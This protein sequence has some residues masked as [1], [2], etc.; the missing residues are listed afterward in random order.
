MMNRRCSTHSHEL[1]RGRSI[2]VMNIL[3]AVNSTQVILFITRPGLW[4]GV[5]VTHLKLDLRTLPSG[6]MPGRVHVGDALWACPDTTRVEI[7]TPKKKARPE[8]TGLE[9]LRWFAPP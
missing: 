8:A 9:N 6:P 7:R 1:E 2:Q 5:E 3:R 4:P